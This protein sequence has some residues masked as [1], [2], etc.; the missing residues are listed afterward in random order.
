MVLLAK[1]IL[2][3]SPNARVAIITGRDELDKQIERIFRDARPCRVDALICR[4]RS[5]H[6]VAGT[7]SSTPAFMGCA[8][9]I[10]LVSIVMMVAQDGG[11]VTQPPNS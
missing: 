1:W 11:K 8:P 7:P 2:E 5:K 10:S 3:N 4:D 6:W 9:I